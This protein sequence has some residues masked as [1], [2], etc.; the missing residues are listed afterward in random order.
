MLP[1]CHLAANGLE[2]RAATCRA[3]PTWSK[4][5]LRM[6]QRIPPGPLYGPA[7]L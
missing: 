7:T 3:V 2:D 6:L 4:A 5:A 1:V